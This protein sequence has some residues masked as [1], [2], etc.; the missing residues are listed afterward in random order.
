VFIDDGDNGAFSEVNQED[1]PLVRNDPGLH[2]LEITSP[3]DTSSVGK[4]FRV[5]IACFNVE[6]FTFSDI[7]SITLADAPS[8]PP[9]PV[10]KIQSLST[11]SS[12]AVEFD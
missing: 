5:K 2:Q 6:G 1:D 8:Q 7:A 4:T 12:L 9:T 10:R 11:A 3:F